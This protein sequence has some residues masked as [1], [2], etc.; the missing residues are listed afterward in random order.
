M[1][2]PPRS[3]IARPRPLGASARNSPTRR[4][5]AVPPTNTAG[6]SYGLGGAGTSLGAQVS[7]RERPGGSVT[8]ASAHARNPRMRYPPIAEHGVIGDLHTVAL[9]AVDGT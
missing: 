5:P 4:R 6:R 9:V 7:W 3:T 1:P 8:A 2:R